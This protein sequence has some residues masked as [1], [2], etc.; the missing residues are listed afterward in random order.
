MKS[1]TLPIVLGVLAVVSHAA[2]S[3]V[4]RQARQAPTTL[5]VEF[6]GASDTT[7]AYEVDVFL[8]TDENFYSFNISESLSSLFGGLLAL[9]YWGLYICIHRESYCHY[10]DLYRSQ[11]CKRIS[12]LCWW[13]WVLRYHWSGWQP[14]DGKWR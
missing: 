13:S 9:L 14:D 11:S 12:H 6:F 2:P 4:Q 3:P 10:P 8:A 5:S 1:L 7:P